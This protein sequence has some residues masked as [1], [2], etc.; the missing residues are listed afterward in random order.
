[1]INTSLQVGSVSKGTDRQVETSTVGL[2]RE[3]VQNLTHVCDAIVAM[4]GS[5]CEAII[6]DFIDI[7]HS[8]VYIAGN[9]TDRCVGGSVTDLLLSLIESNPT[10]S[11]PLSYFARSP[12]GHRLKCVSTPIYDQYSGRIQGA[13]CIN[14]DIEVYSAA[15]SVLDTLIGLGN[16]GNYQES[17]DTKPEDIVIQKTQE[18]ATELGLDL[19]DLGSEDRSDIVRALNQRGVF[20]FKSAHSIVAEALGVSRATIYNYLKRLP[21]S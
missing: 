14:F 19:S 1:M 13:L 6:H 12:R 7:E 20:A 9:V 17:F 8:I 3:L 4:M 18:A 2:S 10:Q 11:E 5:N 21:G 16:P 15:N